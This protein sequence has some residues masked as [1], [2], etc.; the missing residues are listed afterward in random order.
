MAVLTAA[1]TLGAAAQADAA[2]FYWQDSD[3]GYYRPAPSAQPR[4]QRN[5][6]KNSAAKSDAVQKETGAKPQGPLVI[7][8]SID[9]QKV[10]V[11]DANGLFAE[12][13]VSTGMKGHSTPMGVFSIIQK[14]KFHHSNIYS[15][16][17]MPYMQRITWS[18]VAM[19]AG[20]LPGYPASHG[21]I[22]MP[23]AFAVKM[24]N[25]TKMGARVVV[26]PGDMTPAS[27]SHP[28]L[29]AQKVTP[30]PV[31]A[32][33]PKNDLLKN[34]L[35]KNDLPKADMPAVKSDKGADAGSAIRSENSV[36]SLELRSTVGHASPLREQTR[37]ADAS[38][39]MPA[40]TAATMSDATGGRPSSSEAAS[41][42][43]KPEAPK[44]ESRP[45]AESTPANSADTAS[46]DDKSAEAS[47]A[48]AISDQTGSVEK[49]D[50]PTAADAAK[51]ETA[52]DS[53]K[54]QE[55]AEDKPAEAKVE[56]AKPEVT[57][58]TETKAP[59]KP[60]EAI[61]DAPA[62]PDAKKDTARLPGIDKAAAA[63]AEPKR[64]G[65]IA[66]F[67]SRKDSKLYVRQNFAPLFD[68]PVTIAP[69][70]RPLGTHVFTAEADKNDPNL[71]RWSVV[72]L[73]VTARN[74]ARNDDDDDRRAR[75]RKIAGGAAAEARP[76]PAPDSPAEAL[77]RITIPQDAMARITE[78]LTTGSS[79][80]VSDQGIN[81]GET[82]EGTDFIVSLR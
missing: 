52:S 40:N 75:R 47:R 46:S 74:A 37:T 18:G 80:I 12:S 2:L 53:A 24:W 41:A 16:A 5:T 61:A 39:P 10:R 44:S 64:T 6:R 55:T 62:A 79:I 27:F 7:A 65:Q 72:S 26:T 25:W 60:A 32:D 9:R 45:D 78:A 22:R 51:A 29:V 48:D 23:M 54:V 33:E 68:V 77:D 66:V 67:V 17:P 73:P 81:Q 15:G 57:K 38:S 4:R 8:I 76:L 56:A 31:V 28:L 82:G 70:D 30:Q 71:L 43:A 21:C 59:D 50:A 34:D 36:T 42:E 19:H 63:K 11:Y 20:V 35:L 13:P 69:S 1:G 49:A 14:H 3:P 58:T